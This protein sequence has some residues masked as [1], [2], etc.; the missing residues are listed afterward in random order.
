MPHA[1]RE[2]SIFVSVVLRTPLTSIIGYLDLLTSKSYQDTEEQDR[3]IRNTHKKAIH[4]K[5]LSMG[6]NCIGSLNRCLLSSRWLVT[7]SSEPST[8]CC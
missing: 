5:Y 8:I 4:L 1:D 6:F 7:R 3:F 2:R